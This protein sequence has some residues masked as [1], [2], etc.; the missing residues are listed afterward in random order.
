MV[1]VRLENFAQPGQSLRDAP[2]DLKVEQQSML[3]EHLL[4][5]SSLFI[6]YLQSEKK[7]QWQPFKTL[8]Q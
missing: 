7:R 8:L 2:R 6:V 1:Q 4:Y 3:L 5:R